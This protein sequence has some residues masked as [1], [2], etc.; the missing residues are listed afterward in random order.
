MGRNPLPSQNYESHLIRSRLKPLKTIEIQKTLRGGGGG[1]CKSYGIT[2]GAEVTVAETTVAMSAAEATAGS[3]R[4]HER[5]TGEHGSGC[6][7]RA[8]YAQGL[9]I[10]A[11]KLGHLSPSAQVLADV[12]GPAAVTDERSSSG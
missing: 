3:E 12:L 7:E 9:E 2:S 11:V 1:G 5:V 4:E 6:S 10:E 8:G